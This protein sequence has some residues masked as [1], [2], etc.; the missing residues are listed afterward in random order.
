MQQGRMQHDKSCT[1]HVSHLFCLLDFRLSLTKIGFM[2]KE[3]K[4]IQIGIP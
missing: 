3:E 1:Q 2:P 4:K